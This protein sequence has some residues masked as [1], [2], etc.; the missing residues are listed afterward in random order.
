MEIRIVGRGGQGVVTASKIIAIAA[1]LEGYYS[2]SMPFFG[3]ERRGALVKS[4]TR[5]SD[6][7][8]FRISQVY[9]PDVIMVLDPLIIKMNVFSGLKS[10]GFA[11]INSKY[12]VNVCENVI[13]VDANEI[14][15]KH[16]IISGGIPVPNIPMLGAFLKANVPIR[17]ETMLEAITQNFGK[18]EEII[19]SFDEGFRKS[20]FVKQRQR[21]KKMKERRRRRNKCE[22]PI[23]FPSEGVAGETKLWRFAKPIIDAEK[24]N[25]CMNCWLHCPE[26]VI[27]EGEDSVIINYDFCKGCLICVDVCKRNAIKTIQEVVN[28]V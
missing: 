17:Y 9:N 13:Y 6:K 20:K 28:Y 8:I 2:Q 12:P 14:A 1:Y 25:K 24:C 27:M 18:R 23:S 22:I 7:P 10:D 5:I 11:V 4:F 26:G 21:R 15:T 3:A 16:E 19:E